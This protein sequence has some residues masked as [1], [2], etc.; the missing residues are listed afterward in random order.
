MFRNMCV[1]VSD[2]NLD[3]NSKIWIRIVQKGLDPFRL[4]S[5]H[6]WLNLQVEN[7]LKELTGNMT[8]TTAGTETARRSLFKGT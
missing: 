6:H 8:H 1:C 5:I 7:M 3:T 4:G 2:P